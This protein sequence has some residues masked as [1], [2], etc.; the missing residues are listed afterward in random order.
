MLGVMLLMLGVIL[1]FGNV[2]NPRGYP[3]VM[4]VVLVVGAMLMLG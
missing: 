2:P 4:F 1:L 3:R